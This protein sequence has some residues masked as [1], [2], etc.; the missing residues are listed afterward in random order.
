MLFHGSSVPVEHP[1]VFHSKRFLDFGSGFYATSFR[2][3]AERWARRKAMRTGGRPFL[4][5]FMLADDL[6]AWKVL[7]FEDDGA[8]LDFV[9]DCRRGSETFLQYD[10]VVGKVADD[11][12]FK[13]VDAFV[14]GLW[15]RE[16]ALQELRYSKAND[17]YAFI[18]QP[19]L[20]ESLHFVRAFE[21]PL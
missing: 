12:V 2:N 16:R 5:E 19:A 1:D 9:C 21:L 4:S 8:W 6:S 15:S 7:R 20:D 10:I 14:R 17:Q 3:Q 11:D 18:S 13:T